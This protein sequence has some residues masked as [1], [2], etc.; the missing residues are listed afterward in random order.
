MSLIALDAEGRKFTNCTG[1][2]FNYEVVGG[3]FRME[4]VL[5]ASWDDLQ[6]FVT[7]EDSL[8]MIKLKSRFERM[9]NKN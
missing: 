2:E 9:T 6:R 5:P 1:L 8:E 7:E 4:G 3:S